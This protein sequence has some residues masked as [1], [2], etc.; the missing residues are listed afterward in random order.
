MYLQTTS[1]YCRCWERNAAKDQT[2]ISFGWF[3]DSPPPKP[4]IVLNERFVAARYEERCYE[5][6]FFT[7]FLVPEGLSID[8]VGVAKG[9][10]FQVVRPWAGFTTG[11]FVNEKLGGL[12]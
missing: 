4:G 6:Y 12:P 7:S 8:A 10:V 3:Y 9:T 2:Y 5:K 11:D 1:F